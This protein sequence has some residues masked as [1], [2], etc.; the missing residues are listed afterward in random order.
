MAIKIVTAPTAEPVTITEAKS[1]LRVDI[2]DDDAFIAEQ[3]KAAREDCASFQNRCYYTTVYELWL[4]E[5]PEDDHIDIPLPPL[6]VPVV[7]AGAFVIG[8]TYRILTVGTTNFTLIGAAA[9][10][11]GTVFTATGAGS[12]TGTATASVIIRYYGTDNTEYAMSGAD[13]LADDKSEPG[14]VVLAYGCQWPSTSLRTANAV[15]ITFTAGYS[16]VS[17]IP[18]V[19]KQAILLLVGHY[20]E[21]RESVTDKQMV[22]LPQAVESLLW[23]NRVF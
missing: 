16:S 7:T 3:I 14:R 11:A 10:T 13:Y 6:Q 4:D 21:H 19:V 2:G 15:C 23:K 17:D 9:N 1:Q 12:G 22:E 18:Q 20:Y 5:F 8:M